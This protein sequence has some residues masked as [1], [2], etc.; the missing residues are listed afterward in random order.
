[1]T[2]AV[3]V[4]DQDGVAPGLNH[5]LHTVQEPIPRAILKLVPLRGHPQPQRRDLRARARAS[6]KQARRCRESTLMSLTTYPHGTEPS[7][8]AVIA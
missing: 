6:P 7:M 3:P 1:M 5:K 4:A 8:L 2:L